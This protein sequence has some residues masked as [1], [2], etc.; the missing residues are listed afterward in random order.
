MTHVYPACVSHRQ[1]EYSTGQHQLHTTRKRTREAAR[2][3]CSELIATVETK[4]PFHQRHGRPQ[5]QPIHLVQTQNRDAN[6]DS[7]TLHQ[8]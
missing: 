7:D 5:L 2:T 8:L 1:K 4:R 3:N 6:N